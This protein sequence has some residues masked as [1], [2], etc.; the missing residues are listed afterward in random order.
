MNFIGAM[1]KDIDRSALLEPLPYLV[2][3]GVKKRFVD[4]HARMTDIAQKGKVSGDSD[5][6]GQ[7]WLTFTSVEYLLLLRRAGAYRSC[8]HHHS[9]NFALSEQRIQC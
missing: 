4:L 9:C 7:I 3:P 6:K 1:A 2:C 8:I 5:L